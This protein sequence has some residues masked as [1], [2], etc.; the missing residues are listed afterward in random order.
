[1]M[2]SASLA[3]EARSVYTSGKGFVYDHVSGDKVVPIRIDADT[4]I[5]I[6]VNAQ[7]RSMKGLLLLFVK[8]YAPGARDSEK[9]GFP[10]LKKVSITI[11]GSPNMIH[12]EGI[13]REDMWSEVSRFV[14]KEKHKP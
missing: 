12:N 14:M 10:D 1:M 13:E 2:R 6:T 5:N 4:R 3:N 11:N 9:Y 8:P 7:R